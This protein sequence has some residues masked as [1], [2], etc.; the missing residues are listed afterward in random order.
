MKYRIRNW[1]DHQHYKD[2][3]PPWV[4]LH[5]GILS[6]RDWVMWND[7]SRVLAVACIVLAAKTGGE[8]D[9][10][11][12]GLEYIKFSAYLKGTPNLKPLIDSGFLECLQVASETLADASGSVSVSSCDSPSVSPE[13]ASKNLRLREGA[14]IPDDLKISEPE[15][16]DWLKYKAERKESYKSMGLGALWRRI[17]LIPADK[18]REAIDHSMAQGWKGIYEKTGGNGGTKQTAGYAEAQRGKYP[19]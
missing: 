4:K 12:G 19:D 16:R 15:I 3:N 13:D 10:S 2:R 1:H 14:T 11:E 7:A 17:R 5:V 6:S 9:G 8:I 18:R